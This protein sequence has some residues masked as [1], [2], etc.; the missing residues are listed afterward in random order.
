M[1]TTTKTITALFTLAGAPK[2][3]LTATVDIW[4]VSDDTRVVTA[5]AMT[6]LLDG[7]A[8]GFYKH[9]FAAFD[10]AED[11]AFKVDAGVTAP[12]NVDAQFVYGTIAEVRE[13]IADQVWDEAE[14]DHIAVGSTGLAMKIARTFLQN[15]RILR[16]ISATNFEYEVFEDGGAVIFLSG[17]ID[18]S[19]S[20]ETR[21]EAS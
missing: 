8:S 21:T 10:N 14:A 9:D 12:V 7:A 6:E 19:G 1:P 5:G 17:T 3:G 15:K 4:R 16:E 13:Q 18:A 2:T 20:E 11:Y